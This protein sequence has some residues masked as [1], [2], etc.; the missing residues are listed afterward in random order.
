[1]DYFPRY[2]TQ[3]LAIEVGCGQH[4]FNGRNLLQCLREKSSAELLKVVETIKS[5]YIKDRQLYFPDG[6]IPDLDFRPVID[7]NRTYALFKRNPLE[8]FEN[9]KHS[10]KFFEA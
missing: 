7:S 8:M 6:P 1:M 2:Q 4:H 9:G 5:N 3:T 10:D